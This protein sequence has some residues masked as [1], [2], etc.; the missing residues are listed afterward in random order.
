[1]RLSINKI[2][3][4][5]LVSRFA[6][7]IF[8]GFF[9][10][11]LGGDLDAQGI[12]DFASAVAKTGSFDDFEIGYVPYSNFLG[13]FYRLTVNHIFVGSILSCIA[14]VGSAYILRKSFYLMGSNIS[15]T[16][17]AL[18]LYALLP[19]SFMF[20]A[21]TLREPYQLLFM[22]IAIYS[23]LEI[24]L[25]KKNWHWF[26]FVLAIFGAGVLH[27]ALLAFG[28][29]I[30][31]GSLILVSMPR[32]R[33]ASWLGF[34]LIGVSVAFLL[35]YGY[36]WFS[37]FS[38]NISA[39]LDS[40]VE[41]YQLGVLRSDGRT[42]YI[43]DVSVSSFGELI[44]F[45]PIS[46]FKYLFEPF[47]WHVS[48]SIDLGLLIE[49]LVRVWLIWKALKSVQFASGEK[50]RLLVFFFISY[51]VMEAIWSLGTVNWGTSVRH[52]IPALGFLLLVA[53]SVG[54][55]KEIDEYVY[56]KEIRKN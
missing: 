53:F 29:I 54:N 9:G 49:N 20:T 42:N 8:N 47:P 3:I 30:L 48:S 26:S 32:E 39:G 44:F 28:F 6:I 10:P 17:N 21:V 18:L 33:G 22:N 15:R 45:F 52:H 43:S 4:F 36:I 55:S 2:I 23:V 40:S 35:S 41:E 56:S 11:T 24:Y 1:M 27:G 7:A 19:S 14:W 37:D 13:A 16:K 5:G 38:Y 51:I 12:N 31:S 46:F 50:H 34:C 25:F